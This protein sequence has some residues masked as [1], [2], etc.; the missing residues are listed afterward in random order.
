MIASPKGP[1]GSEWLPRRAGLLCT[2]G[3]WGQ[4]HHH[5]PAPPSPWGLK[6]RQSFFWPHDP[7]KWLQ[8]PADP[9]Q[10]CVW[11][12]FLQSC[13]FFSLK[14]PF[15]RGEPLAHCIL[16][17]RGTLKTILLGSRTGMWQVGHACLLK[18]LLQPHFHVLPLTSGL[19]S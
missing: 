9:H 12:F 7:S 1:S 6:N 10:L 5:S 3:T 11:V 17:L 15:Q 18:V 19:E 4:L 8:F 14:M 2:P 13:R 16:A